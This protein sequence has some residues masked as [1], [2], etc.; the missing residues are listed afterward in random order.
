VNCLTDC[1]ETGD[2]G[3]CLAEN[4]IEEIGAF[5]ACAAPIVARGACDT[6]LAACEVDMSP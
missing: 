3:A 1:V 2:I 4:C 6:D 5:D